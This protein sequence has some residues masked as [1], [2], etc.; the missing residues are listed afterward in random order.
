MDNLHYSNIS[1]Q[2]DK[3]GVI[4]QLHIGNIYTKSCDIPIYSFIYEEYTKIN[5]SCTPF[6]DKSSVILSR[7]T[8]SICFKKTFKHP[9]SDIEL[10]LKYNISIT[11]DV[12]LM[13]IVLLTDTFQNYRYGLVIPLCSSNIHLYNNIQ[14]YHP[15]VNFHRIW[16]RKWPDQTYVDAPIISLDGQEKCCS[17][18][19]PIDY[20]LQFFFH[21]QHNNECVRISTSTHSSKKLKVLMVSHKE[22]AKDAYIKQF[23]YADNYINFWKTTFNKL[24]KIHEINITYGASCNDRLTFDPIPYS[25]IS[26]SIQNL[27]KELTKYN[28]SFKNT[29]LK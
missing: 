11:N 29:K 15:L 3:S 28:C 9:Y 2:V 16:E 8:T 22:Y 24:Y 12:V 17:I 10:D 7:S 13:N 25:S 20:N 21:K 14:F 6:V 26:D 4:N 23:P 27:D 18:F 19:C 1:C 5:P